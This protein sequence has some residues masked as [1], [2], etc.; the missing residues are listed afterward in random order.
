LKNGVISI[1][2]EIIL[3]DQQINAGDLPVFLDEVSKKCLLEEFGIQRNKFT[4]RK[5]SIKGKSVNNYISDSKK[6]IQ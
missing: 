2:N 1:F 5:D 4:N 3:L 6:G